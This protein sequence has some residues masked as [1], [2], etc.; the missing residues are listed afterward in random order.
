MAVLLGLVHCS[1]GLKSVPYSNSTVE[2]FYVPSY[3]V[4]LPNQYLA[5]VQQYNVHIVFHFFKQ[6]FGQQYKLVVYAHVEALVNVS[7]QSNLLILCNY[8][9]TNM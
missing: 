9:P 2:L 3:K 4:M 1:S 6:R 8:N 7:T 5:T